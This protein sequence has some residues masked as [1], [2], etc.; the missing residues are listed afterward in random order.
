MRMGNY[1]FIPLFWLNAFAM[2]VTLWNFCERLNAAARDKNALCR[3]VPPI[4]NIGERSFVYLSLNQVVVA[5]VFMLMPTENISGVLTLI[6]NIICL[7]IVLTAL[8]PLAFVREKYT[9]LR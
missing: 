3:F 4:V 1:G 6:H 7:F 9:V 5:L 2:C 8:Y